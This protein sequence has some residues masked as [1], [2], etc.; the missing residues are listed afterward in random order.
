[1]PH[2]RSGFVAEALPRA[3]L[4]LTCLAHSFSGYL[5]TNETHAFIGGKH[6]L[7]HELIL[8]RQLPAN[9]GPALVDQAA[10]EVNCLG[11]FLLN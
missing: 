6:P 5:A 1:M 8:T 4:A 10:N 2:V 7:S 11:K 9:P 3:P